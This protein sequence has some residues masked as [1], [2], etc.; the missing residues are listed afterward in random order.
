MNN[1]KILFIISNMESGGVSK[2]MTNLLSVIDRTRYDISLLVLNPQGVFMDLLPSDI[3]IIS[4]KNITALNCRLKGFVEL[5][6][7]RRP[8]LAIGHLFRLAVSCIN[9]GYAGWIISRLM[10]P[11][12]DK[13]DVIVD[14]NGQQQ[15]YYMVDKLNGDKKITFFHNDY[16]KW[17]YYYN[18]DRKYFPKVDVIFSISEQCVQS[19][20]DY[21]PNESEK[22]YLMEN[23][24][25]PDLIRRLSEQQITD[26]DS[27]KPAF[28][29]VG[30]ICR[31]KG[32]DTAIKAASILKTRGIDFN[33]YFIGKVSNDDDYRALAARYNVTEKIHFLGIKANPYPY[34]KQATIYIHPSLFEGKSISLDEAK[35]LCKPIVVT[36]FSTVYD[37]FTDRV[38]GSI[39]AMN[40]EDLADTIEEL[41]N[42]D[43]LRNSYIRYLSD[44]TTDNC[45]E[46][47][48]LYSQFDN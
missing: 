1:K 19:L 26:M 39:C 47:A 33:W 16:R 24:S 40:A 44:H 3:R 31:R 37:Q 41:L 12:N 38:N 43:D 18:I 5:I 20:K 28:L 10:P 29:T 9:K 8:L 42:N 32:S 14:Y 2:S 25:S 21:F 22:I 15:L 48:K 11:L 46:I 30:H 17:P 13:F 4:D 35:I 45:N 23:I 6:K 36:N 34:L 27:S 7:N